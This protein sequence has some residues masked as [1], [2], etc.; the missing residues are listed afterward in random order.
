MRDF[1]GFAEFCTDVLRD[2]GIFFRD[3][4]RTSDRST[5][6]HVLLSDV[7]AERLTLI[8]LTNSDGLR[9]QSRLDE[10]DVSRSAFATAFLAAFPIGGATP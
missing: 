7:P 2:G 3:Y 5:L 8:L 4:P 6:R 9:W 1:R 10:A